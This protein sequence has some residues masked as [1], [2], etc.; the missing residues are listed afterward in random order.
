MSNPEID[1]ETKTEIFKGHFPHGAS[2]QSL[3]H[4]GQIRTADKFK[5]FDYRDPKKN[6]EKYGQTRP[7][8]ID[9]S[10]ISEV[11][12]AMY[13]GKEDQIVDVDSNRWVR[14]QIK[15]VVHY[16]ELNHDHFSFQ[17]AEDMSYFEDV[18]DMIHDH[19]PVS[20]ENREFYEKRR[21]ELRAE[22]KAKE[23]AEL[24]E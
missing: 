10:T 16:E 6:F 19:N 20:E 14:D 7:P 15:S 2:V 21:E 1:S 13:V 23:M 11:P 5:K 12:I 22:M 9:I 24:F 18:V 4:Y 17:L 8:E 3:C